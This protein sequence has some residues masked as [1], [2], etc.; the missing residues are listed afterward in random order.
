MYIRGALQDLY[1]ETRYVYLS[2]VKG[3]KGF[4]EKL[5]PQG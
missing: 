1:N 3:L 4:Y 5:S 2:P